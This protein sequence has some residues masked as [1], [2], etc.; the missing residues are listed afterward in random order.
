M[1]SLRPR[2]QVRRLASFGLTTPDAHRLSEFYQNALDFRLLGTERRTGAEFERLM[3]DRSTPQGIAE[4][5]RMMMGL[6][7]QADLPATGPQT[8]GKPVKGDGQGKA[9]AKQSK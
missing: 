1:E 7:V 4:R 6:L 3:G 9:E 2:A 8:P 5:A